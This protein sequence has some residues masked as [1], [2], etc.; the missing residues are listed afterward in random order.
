MRRSRR[1]SFSPGSR[2][3][4]RGRKR[5][6]FFVLALLG[7]VGGSFF[8]RGKVISVPDGDTLVLLTHDLERRRIRLYGVDCPEAA[9]RG[10]RT[11]TEFTESL[12]LF[13]EVK[14]TV[15]ERDRYKRDVALVH[16]ADGRLLNEELVR[17]GHAWVY[18][19]Y[20]RLP[21]CL[22]WRRLESAAREQRLGLWQEDGSVPP[23]KWRGQNRRGH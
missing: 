6:L 18:D 23:W 7:I 2:L 3:T 1:P 10:G 22:D 15:V 5:I 19:A 16:L 13:D 21:R 11:A 20:C 4:R 14:I 9:Q 12:T 17:F 8:L